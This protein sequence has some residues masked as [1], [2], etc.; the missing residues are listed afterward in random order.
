MAQRVIKLNE[1]ELKGLIKNVLFE[2]AG[3]NDDE[4]NNELNSVLNKYSKQ[5]ALPTS[6][7]AEATAAEDAAETDIAAEEGTEGQG[8]FYI[9]TYSDDLTNS[10]DTW[11]GDAEFK[12]HS[13]QRK[14]LKKRQENKVLTLKTSLMMKVKEWS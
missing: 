1:N 9:I 5:T 14:M 4:E 2:I 11:I 7:N 8:E 3:F 13:Q 12:V 10:T 6:N